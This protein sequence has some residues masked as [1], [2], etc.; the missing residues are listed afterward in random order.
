MNRKTVIFTVVLIVLSFV[1]SWM[2]FLASPGVFETWKLQTNDSLFRL[3]YRIFG[4]RPTFPSIV[5]VDFDDE[6]A[7][8]MD[9]SMDDKVLY[10]KII[11]LL[12]EA[13]VRA[14]AF[15]MVFLR[16]DSEENDEALVDATF[17]S[18]NIYFPIILKPKSAGE[19]DSASD[20]AEAYGRLLSRILWRPSVL[21]QAQEIRADVAFSTFPDLAEAARGIGHITCYPDRDGVFRRFPLLIRVGDGYV[22]SLSFRMACDYL[23]VSPGEMKVAFGQD[24][25]LPRAQL[26]DGREKDTVIP[27]DS[28]GRIIINFAGPWSDSFFHYPVSKLL[29][30]EEDR[31]LLDSLTDEIE[32]NLVVVSDVSTG[33]RDIGPVPL[34][35]LYPLSGLHVNIINSIIKEDFV[36]ELTPAQELLI[37]FALIALLS[38][39]AY[40]FRGMGFTFS[41]LLL[42]VLY[43]FFAALLFFYRGILSNVVAP[44]F[45]VLLSIVA[46]NVYKYLL[47][48]KEKAFIRAKFE[49]YF[50]PELLSKILKTPGML[51]AVEQKELSILFSDIS[52]FT[53][54]SSVQKPEY[55]RQTLNQYFEEMARIVFK[56]G[57]TIDKYMG[58]GMM[59]FFGDPLTQEDHALRAVKSAVEMQLKTRELRRMWETEGGMPIR[60]RV[61]INTGEVVVGNMGSSRR[62]DYTTIGANVNLAQ[63]LESGAPVGGI[64]I[65][66][67]VCDKVK[68]EIEV[69]ASGTIEA[70]GFSEPVEVFEVVLPEPHA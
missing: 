20:S 38:A 17:E 59:V 32:E 34:E 19:S 5:H 21:R 69:R 46:V 16:G 8:T 4:K 58:D 43:L 48:E 68:D 1:L 15:D 44:S 13:Y 3:R 41:A 29:Q 37:S 62:L 30:A 27:I 66:K 65:T 63:R 2:L 18:N 14:V 26:P 35:N 56:Y 22:P 51:D 10:T 57:G 49:N 23:G 39:G 24:I 36:D 9:V 42:L 67:T 53:A 28:Q 11:D 6:S 47:E 61:G 25:T 33:G 55:I 52:G 40:K 7:R 45:A 70:K 60:I 12:S 31:E 50:A 54:W 64:L